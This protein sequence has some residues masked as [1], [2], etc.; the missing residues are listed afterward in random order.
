MPPTATATA[1]DAGR[2]LIA[3]RHPEYAGA[4]DTWRFLYDSYEGGAHYRD[5]V[6]SSDRHGYPTHYLLRHKREYPAP[7]ERWGPGDP[8]DDFEL[9][10]LRTPVPDFVA[11]VVRKHL[12]RIYAREVRR[13][14]NPAE[15]EAW[16]RDVDGRGT[17]LDHW[18]RHSY[19][20]LLYTLGTLDVLCDHPRAPDGEPIRTDAD[21]RRLGLS[22]VVARVVMPWDVL[23]WR[24][25][26][27]GSYAEVLD[28]EWFVEEEDP[29]TGRRHP[30]PRRV[31]RHRHWTAEG[32]TLYDA[33]G[34]QIEA[35]S[36]PFGRVP[37]IRR[38]VGEKHRCEAVG[39]MPLERAAMIMR[40]YYNRDSEL[41]LSDVLQ[42][43][44]T[45]Q[46]PPRPIGEGPDV[47]VGPGWQLEK[48]RTPE[49]RYEGYD[50]LDFPKGGAESIRTNLAKLRD[51]LDRTY[52]LA[53]PAGSTSVGGAGGSV[54]AQS[55]VSK[56][57][58]AATLNDMLA[59]LSD[60]LADDEAHLG[61]LVMAVATD[62]RWDGG[63]AG[64][65]VSYPK[66]FDLYSAD[67]LA[68]RWLACHD[69]IAE[70]RSTP[71]ATAAVVGVIVRDHLLPGRS[72]AEYRAIDDEVRAAIEAR[73]AT[74]E[75]LTARLAGAPAGDTR[76]DEEP[77][78]D[79][80]DDDDDD[81]N[82][83]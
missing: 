20:P 47:V 50:V 33:R 71:E 70:G 38:K 53:K 14:G 37:Q 16:A 34:E 54:V 51:E 9:R 23:W 57:Y 19:A 29:A 44:P 28:R 66:Q 58:D 12:S 74:A 67:E 39:S 30:T 4:V 40:E 26:P 15:Y 18:M 7:G 55:G 78:D 69:L 59:E 43:H 17:S 42:A 1:T 27:D 56:G 35:D 32:W 5:R 3:R 2:E 21:R 68:A 49:G 61:A 64:I 62:G 6:L 76:S 75:A 31:A 36:H 82:P 22:R 83:T 25:D 10:R 8:E 65:T 79:D 13:E 72:D 81:P 11:E 63:T 60:T 73:A 77:E 24:L 48:V 45:I 46:G 41:I 52:A 80:D